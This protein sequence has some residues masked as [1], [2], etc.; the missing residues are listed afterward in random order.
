LEAG[1]D[2]SAIGFYGDVSAW[3]EAN[4]IVYDVEMA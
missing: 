2:T 3:V 4:E 1:R